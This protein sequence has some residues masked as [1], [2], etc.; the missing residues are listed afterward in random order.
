M[1]KNLIAVVSTLLLAAC[2]TNESNTTLTGSTLASPTASNS[3]EIA[4]DALV[5]NLE[6]LPTNSGIN[7]DAFAFVVKGW[8]KIGNNSC[9]AAGLQAKFEV[10]KV[11]REIHVRPIISGTPTSKYCTLQLMPVSKHIQI[12]INGLRDNV[13]S[14]VVHNVDKA[15]NNHTETVNN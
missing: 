7:P 9:A 15:G 8:V 11:N 10:T 3:A 12:A 4:P 2:G 6:V 14:F 1:K 13:D 5:R